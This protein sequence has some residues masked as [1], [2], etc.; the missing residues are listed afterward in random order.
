[1][2]KG[3]IFLFIF[4]LILVLTLNFYWIIP[5]EQIQFRETF[6]SGSSEFSL[7]NNSQDSMLFYENMR[8]PYKEISYKIEESCSIKKKQDMT[9]A[10]DVIENLSVLDFYPSQDGEIHVSCQERIVRD[11][12]IFIAGEGGPTE[13]IQSGKYNI[14]YSGDI[15]LIRDSGCAEPQVAIHELLHV[16]GFN[17]SENERNI[18]Y[19][20]SK[21][22]QVIGNEIPEKIN[23]LY[24]DSSLPD[25][26]F[27]EINV[28]ARARFLD[29]NLTIR[30]IGIVDSDDSVLKLYVDG[31]EIKEYSVRELKPGTGIRL[32]STNVF[33]KKADVEKIEF[34]IINDF[35]ELDKENN[36]KELV[37]IVN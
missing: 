31:K 3:L 22:S 30:N 8:F 32:W 12:G 6:S 5:P 34:E 20:Y 11:K 4:L 13:I 7:D 27:N 10:F 9:E 35:E 21:C 16:L 24:V 28:S 1:M 36:K 33:I 15:L 2:K 14:I 18:M 26:A 19:P 37:S 17:H 23:E 29:F 25:L